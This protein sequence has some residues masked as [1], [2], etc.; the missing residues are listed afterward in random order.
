MY[1]YMKTLI[2]AIWDTNWYFCYVYLSVWCIKPSEESQEEASCNTEASIG[3]IE[4][5]S[6]AAN[7][8]TGNRPVVNVSSKRKNTAAADEDL[9]QNWRTA[10]GPPPPMGHSRVSLTCEKSCCFMCLMFRSS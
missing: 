3:D 1:M 10:L 4:D 8:T 6:A 9:S 5:I 7:R 2:C